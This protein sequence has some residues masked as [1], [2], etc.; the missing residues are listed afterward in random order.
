[1][2][3]KVCPHCQARQGGGA[4]WAQELAGLAALFVLAGGFIGLI[5]IIAPEETLEGR[6]FTGR[7]SEL[8]MGAVLVEK[9]RRAEEFRVTG[10]V[11]NVG[12]HPWRIAE[13]E[14]R[15]RGQDGDLLDVQ[16]HRMTESFVVQPGRD[17]AFG[18][19]FWRLNPRVLTARLEG[20]VTQATDGNR[21]SSSD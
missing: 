14:I 21:K 4:P 2:A 1:V 11:T 19:T 6:T 7:S 13:L 3:A 17:G 10:V 16:H 20:R 5:A 8:K 15:F 9:G 18:V 12:T